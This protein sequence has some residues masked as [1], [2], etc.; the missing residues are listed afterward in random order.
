MRFAY[1]NPSKFN[2]GDDDSGKG[3]QN[4]L[5]GI[6]QTESKDFN[7]KVELSASNFLYCQGEKECDLVSGFGQDLAARNIQRGRDHGIPSY[8]EFRKFCNEKCN[9]DLSI[10]KSFDEKP[11]DISQENWDNL[12][13][14]YKSVDD[15]DAFT[16][17]VSERN[18]AKPGQ[19]GLVGKTFA[20]IIGVQ[21]VNLKKGD[22]FFF[23]HEANGPNGEQGLEKTIKESIRERSLE[24]IICDNV[25]VSK[26][27][28]N[29]FKIN[30]NNQECDP[31]K[32]PIEL[33]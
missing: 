11:N 6:T 30:S 12:R 1:F 14:V 16:G 25:P 7:S 5:L 4:L 27:S 8:I 9:C 24:D 19:D 31:T 18:L 10:P 17:G 33:P 26:V 3:W 22:R 20:C 23:T 32:N 29:V 15:I 28:E 13:S 21:F 2:I